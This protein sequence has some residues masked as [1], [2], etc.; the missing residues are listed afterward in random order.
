MRPLLSSSRLAVPILLSVLLLDAT[1]ARAEVIGKAQTGSGR[2]AVAAANVSAVRPN[3]LI[4]VVRA[5]PRQRVK[6][7]YI[8]ICSRGQ[9][10]ESRTGSFSGRTTLSRTMLMPFGGADG[11]T[12]SAA[13]Q[14]DGGS[15]R[16]VVRLSAR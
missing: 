11:C 12:A 14:L 7:S 1:A 8:V 5:S 15:G 13:A 2:F 6:G 10:T 3:R 4:V 16:L 9:R